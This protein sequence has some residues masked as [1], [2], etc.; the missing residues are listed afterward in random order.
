MVTEIKE[1]TM[2]PFAVIGLVKT[3]SGLYDTNAALWQELN[4]RGGEIRSLARLDEDGEP[5]GAWG[6]LNN[7]RLSFRLTKDPKAKILYMAGLEVEDTARAP[8][9]FTKWIVPGGDYLYAPVEESKLSTLG[10]ILAYAKDND[11]EPNG[12]PYDFMPPGSREMY[13]FFP[14]Q[15]A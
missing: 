8:K 15:K 6:L 2:E 13:V 10:R 5:M 3:D 11:W 1:C 7:D 14:V 4:Q 9:G 12:Y